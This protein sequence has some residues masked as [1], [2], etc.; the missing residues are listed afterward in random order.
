MP[1]MP[2][3]LGSAFLVAVTCSK[4]LECLLNAVTGTLVPVTAFSKHSKPL[5]QVLSVLFE[6]GRPWLG[7]IR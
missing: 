1:L 4:G 2:Q 3:T 6:Q 7:K 5:E